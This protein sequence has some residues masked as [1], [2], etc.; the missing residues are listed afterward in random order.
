VR[1]VGCECKAQEEEGRDNGTIKDKEE[2]NE[3]VQGC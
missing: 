3:N 1:K 2:D